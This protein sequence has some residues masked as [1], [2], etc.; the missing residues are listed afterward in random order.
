MSS[1][2]TEKAV[3][4]FSCVC[5]SLKG[6]SKRATIWSRRISL[7]LRA[8]PVLQKTRVWFP[9]ATWQLTTISNSRC[10]GLNT[11]S[12]KLGNAHTGRSL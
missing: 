4:H 5:R 9:A 7:R 1:A 2:G 6:T 3:L 10:R 12:A 8:L 11:L